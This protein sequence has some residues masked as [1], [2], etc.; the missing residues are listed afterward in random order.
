MSFFDMVHIKL[1]CFFDM[2]YINLLCLAMEWPARIV[3]EG[4]F[5][6]VTVNRRNRRIDSKNML[7]L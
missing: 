7:D 3:A 1:L 4:E 2:V 6:M 5:R